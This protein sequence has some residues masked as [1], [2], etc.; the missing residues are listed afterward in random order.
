M[1]KNIEQLNNAVKALPLHQCQRNTIVN[2][3][4]DLSKNS[5]N[6]EGGIYI[7]NLPEFP[8]NNEPFEN[9]DKIAKDIIK[10]IDENKQIVI[11]Y[12]M[13]DEGTKLVQ[14]NNI[15]FYNYSI[16]EDYYTIN[17][18]W[19]ITMTTSSDSMFEFTHYNLILTNDNCYFVQKTAILESID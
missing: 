13:E 10:A 8:E 12:S 7:L 14:C 17:L 19:G 1:K 4:A 6:G 3:I 9:Q 11:K 15:N 18:I 2:T 16:S 5:S